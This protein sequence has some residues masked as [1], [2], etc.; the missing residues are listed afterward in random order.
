MPFQQRAPAVRA[1]VGGPDVGAA[2][3]P[4]PP[5][6]HRRDGRRDAPRFCAV[7]R[8][9]VLCR[10]GQKSGRE[11][12]PRIGRESADHAP[13]FKAT[14][15]TRRGPWRPDPCSGVCAVRSHHTSQGRLVERRQQR[16]RGSERRRAFRRPT[17]QLSGAR[18]WRL[19]PAVAVWRAMVRSCGGAKSARRVQFHSARSALAMAAPRSTTSTTADA[20]TKQCCF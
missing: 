18:R 19:V 3:A 14:G 20:R 12:G 2:S 1:D 15:S 13:A 6:R 7:P 9:R 10:W 5:P 16:S 8:R 11:S 17:R 4:G